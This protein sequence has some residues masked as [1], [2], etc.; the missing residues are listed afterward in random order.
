M[1][2]TNN[3]TRS[4][5]KNN[6]TIDVMSTDVHT[7]K[8][9]VLFCDRQRAIEIS[10]GNRTCGFYSMQSCI[11]NIVLVYQVSVIKVGK[12]MM[13]MDDFSSLEFSDLY[14][15]SEFSST[16]RFNILDFTAEYF[17][18]IIY[19]LFYFVKPFYS[20]LSCAI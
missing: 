6:V 9:S 14:M 7:I 13:N 20:T 11:G 10:R 8:C 5:V 15:R 12:E 19:F 17:I 1:A 18:I 4:F 16:V 3:T 2:I